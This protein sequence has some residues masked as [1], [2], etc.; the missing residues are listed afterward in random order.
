MKL[1]LY[2][3]Y[4]FV[5]S[6]SGLRASPMTPQQC[7]HLRRLTAIVQTTSRPDFSALPLDISL[8][9]LR[10]DFVACFSAWLIVV[11]V[12]IVNTSFLALCCACTS[13]VS[14]HHCCGAALPADR[15]DR[16]SLL[17]VECCF[18]CAVLIFCFLRLIVN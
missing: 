6:S 18:S 1:K 8:I 14:Y 3:S 15:W 16:C 10:L 13:L 4:F 9:H 2:A 7:L 12:R 11:F 5:V 17:D